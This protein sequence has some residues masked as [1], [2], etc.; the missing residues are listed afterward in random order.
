MTQQ[1]TDIEEY[2]AQLPDFL[3]LV[4]QQGRKNK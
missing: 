1:A 4:T 3:T 2:M